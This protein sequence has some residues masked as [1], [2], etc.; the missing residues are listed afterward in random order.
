MLKV[1][2]NV[3]ATMRVGG[4]GGGT[5]SNVTQCSFDHEMNKTF[6]QVGGG[7][8]LIQYPMFPNVAPIKKPYKKLEEG[9][10]SPK[11]T[12]TLNPTFN[13]WGRGVTI[14]QVYTYLI[15]MVYDKCHARKSKVYTGPI[16]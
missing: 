15:F 2:P 11:V 10:T 8:Y 4:G 6:F 13:F 16:A 7:A 1:T 3:A 14:G 12:P 9:G 5:S